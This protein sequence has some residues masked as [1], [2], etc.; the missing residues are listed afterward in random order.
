MVK[1]FAIDPSTLWLKIN[2]DLENIC[3]QANKLTHKLVP[4]P[5]PVDFHVE[6]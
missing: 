1:R 4:N 3:S 2:I 5:N 6:T